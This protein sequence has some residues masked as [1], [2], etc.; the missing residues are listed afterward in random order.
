MR[1]FFRNAPKKKPAS[2]L[3][4]FATTPGKS[5]RYTWCGWKWRHTSKRLSTPREK[6]SASTASAPAFTA[7]AEV[8]QMIAKGLTLG[9]GRRSRSAFRT[10][11]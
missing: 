1:R 9:S 4:L 2:H 3:A 7:P 10:P 6:S 8:P 11:T 5:D